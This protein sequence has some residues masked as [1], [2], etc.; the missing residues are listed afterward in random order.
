VAAASCL[1]LGRVPPTHW[2]TRIFYVHVYM[3]MYVGLIQDVRMT[4]L[5]AHLRNSR[6][7]KINFMG[8]KFLYDIHGHQF[9]WLDTSVA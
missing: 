2:R 4:T 6:E 5:Y 9:I 8:G 7:G 1:K 3:Y